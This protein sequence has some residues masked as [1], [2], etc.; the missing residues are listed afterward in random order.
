MTDVGQW[1]RAWTPPSNPTAGEAR[2]DSRTAADILAHIDE[3]VGPPDQESEAEHEARI[4][5]IARDA[6]ARAIRRSAL[7]S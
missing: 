7:R 5:M 1:S 4:R 3:L 6:E 2:M